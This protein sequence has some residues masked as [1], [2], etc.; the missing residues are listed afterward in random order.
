MADISTPTPKGKINLPTIGDFTYNYQF[1]DG[2]AFP[3]GSKLWLLFGDAGTTQV[4]WDFTISGAT[5]TIRKESEDVALIDS[6]TKFWLM[7]SPA[8]TSPTTEKELLTGTV[9]K[10]NA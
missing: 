8:V 6:D 7:Y 2:S 4:R 9:K 3:A 5:A 1:S 10:V